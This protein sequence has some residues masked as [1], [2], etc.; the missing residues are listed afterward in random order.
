[1]LMRG[2]VS[3]ELTTCQCGIKSPHYYGLFLSSCLSLQ[4]QSPVGNVC[5][6]GWS[7]SSC[8]VQ[9]MLALSSHIC[10]TVFFFCSCRPQNIFQSSVME[11]KSLYPAVQFPSL[12]YTWKDKLEPHFVV[13]FECSY[14]VYPCLIASSW[15]L[16]INNKIPQTIF[17]VFEFSACVKV[18]RKRTPKH[19]LLFSSAAKERKPS[20]SEQKLL[21]KHAAFGWGASPLLTLC[22]SRGADLNINAQFVCKAMLRIQITNN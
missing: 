4:N 5:G 6:E 9:H 19:D 3:S 22:P 14:T 18:G 11:R 15:N 10:C 2:P 7:K 12:K 20:V 1:M 21:Y 17:G 8:V 13:C 16:L